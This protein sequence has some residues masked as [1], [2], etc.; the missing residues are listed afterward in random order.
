MTHLLKN[1]FKYS[2]IYNQDI[3]I[4]TTQGTSLY[5]QTS[6]SQYKSIQDL[7]FARDFAILKDILRG[8]D[9]SPLVLMNS[10]EGYVLI[11]K[12][13]YSRFGL[14]IVTI[15]KL[16]PEELFGAVATCRDLVNFNALSEEEKFYAVSV[17]RDE[18]NNDQRAFA[19]GIF[20]LYTSLSEFDEYE[21]SPE[22]TISWMREVAQNISES[23]NYDI[24]CSI[25]SFVDVDGHN[26]LCP[27]SFY[28]STIAFL[29]VASKY[30]ARKNANI[31][32]HYDEN[33]VYCDFSFEVSS[34]Y[35]DR[36]IIL[37]SSNILKFRSLADKNHLILCFG[38]EN[39]TFSMRTYPWVRE[40]DSADI[41]R[42]QRDFINKFL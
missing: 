6:D 3:L 40:P 8:F 17:D 10:K 19:S 30:S 12:M 28:L 9:H 37:T 20:R 32:F 16:A 2:T 41:K 7:L 39:D 34:K 5:P 11:D 36:D 4:F 22:E 14:L 26:K 35:C 1:R 13:L 15:P 23:F 21:S 29:L 25:G 38:Q 27:A 18:L 42:K 31:T 33:G 24:E